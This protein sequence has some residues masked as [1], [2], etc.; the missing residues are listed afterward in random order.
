MGHK[1]KCNNNRPNATI[2]GHF[3]SSLS[4]IEHVEKN[5]NK[6]T[7]GLKYTVDQWFSTFLML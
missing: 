7:P 2:V 3:S 6:I 4:P 5:V 1:V